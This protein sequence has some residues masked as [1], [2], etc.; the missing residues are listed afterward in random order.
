MVAGG[1]AAAVS[2]YSGEVADLCPT[3]IDINDL[4][5]GGR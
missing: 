2:M 1:F 4:A 5:W 3:L